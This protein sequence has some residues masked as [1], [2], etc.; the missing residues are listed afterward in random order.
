MRHHAHDVASLATD[1]RDIAQRAVRIIQIADNHTVLEPGMIL[2][3]EPM[4]GNRHGFYDLEDQ[5]VVTERGA[6]CLHEAAPEDL[7]VI[8]G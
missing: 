4:F 1:S 7:P 8:G 2:S 5:Y 3:V 6:E